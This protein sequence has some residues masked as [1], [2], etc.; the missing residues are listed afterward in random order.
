MGY[1]PS[2]SAFTM[3]IRK[4]SGILAIAAAPAAVMLSSEGITNLPAAFLIAAYESLF[5]AAYTS[6][7]YP[8]EPSVVDTWPDTPSLPL[9]PRPEGQFTEVPVPGPL[10]HSG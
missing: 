5:W 9:A 8:M 3:E 4:S 7:T 2:P 10:F 6:S 1:A